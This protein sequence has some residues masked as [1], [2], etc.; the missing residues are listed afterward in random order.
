MR[1]ALILAMLG[2]Q[3][4]AGGCGLIRDMR[5]EYVANRALGRATAELAGP[6]PRRQG[7]LAELDLAYRLRWRD[8]RFLAR[9]AP[10]YLAAGDYER[11]LEC[12]KVASRVT[13]DDCDLEIGMCYLAL[14]DHDRGVKRLY[15][16]LETAAEAYSNK[17]ASPDEYALVLNDVGYALADAGLRLD[18]AFEMVKQAVQ[19]APLVPAYVDSLGWAYFRHGDDKM[20]AFYLERAARLAGRQDP[21]I[22][23]HLGAVHARLRQFRRAERELKRAIALDPTNEEARRTLN[24][25]R[26]ELPPPAEA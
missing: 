3:L 8:Q 16:A 19:R 18:D 12:Y 6:V 10:H 4:I 9:L 1:I 22:L 14:G 26:H 11:A 23:W 13:G 17:T 25:L 24:R 15:K 20:A 21:E 5:S 2:T 7:A